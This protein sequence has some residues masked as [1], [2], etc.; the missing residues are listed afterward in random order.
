MIY[1]DVNAP[2]PFRPTMFQPDPASRHLGHWRI[3]GH[4]VTIYVWTAEEWAGLPVRPVDAQY[5]ACG[6]WCAL[7]L[8]D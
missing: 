2:L 8:D 1:A 3:N 4:G 7:R 6:I 5:Y